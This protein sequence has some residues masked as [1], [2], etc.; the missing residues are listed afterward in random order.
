MFLVRNTAY[1]KYIYFLYAK[2]NQKSHKICNFVFA[3]RYT[4]SLFGEISYK[5]ISLHAINPFL[6]D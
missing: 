4:A 5:Y 2:E 3:E 6:E 1:W